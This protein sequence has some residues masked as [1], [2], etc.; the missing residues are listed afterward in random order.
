[1]PSRNRS[2]RF[3]LKGFAPQPCRHTELLAKPT[4]I[5][6]LGR[7]PVAARDVDPG[8]L[9]VGR[10]RCRNSPPGKRGPL[11]AAAVEQQPPAAS[12]VSAN[13][14]SM[15]SW[16][17]VSSGPARLGRNSNLAQSLS[18]IISVG[19]DDRR[20]KS[21]GRPRLDVQLVCPGVAFRREWIDN[22]GHGMRG[23][24]DIL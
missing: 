6:A 18:L 17:C 15:R 10:R 2:S 5:L 3:K 4:A 14:K 20:L 22:R 24:M 23:K 13:F 16:N 8:V 19:R 7:P 9:Q 1:M 21:V 11:P 12:P